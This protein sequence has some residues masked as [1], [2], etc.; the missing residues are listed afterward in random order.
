MLRWSPRCLHFS[1]LPSYGT[2]IPAK[3]TESHFMKRQ[4]TQ[5]DITA[6]RVAMVLSI[7]LHVDL[8][9]LINHP[10]NMDPP[11][12]PG[13]TAIPISTRILKLIW[14][15]IIQWKWLSIEA[16][17]EAPSQNIWKSQTKACYHAV[18]SCDRQTD[19]T[20]FYAQLLMWEGKMVGLVYFPHT[21][22]TSSTSPH[23]WMADGDSLKCYIVRMSRLIA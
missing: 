16:P 17:H 10:P 22:P 6:V 15:T 5:R 8:N 12:A 4:N 1:Y 2:V 11:P 19:Q 21:Y 18:K 9:R 13:T 3:D 20:N 14:I 23:M 7:C